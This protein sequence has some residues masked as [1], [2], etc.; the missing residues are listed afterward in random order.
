[1][2]LHHSNGVQR[3]Y[4]IVDCEC[5]YVSLCVHHKMSPGTTA[6][7][8]NANF[9]IHMHVDKVGLPTIFS[10]MLDVFNLIFNVKYLQIYCFAITQ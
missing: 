7:A 1:M 3:W 4:A 10:Q 9:G 8:K 6:E 2:F 5:M